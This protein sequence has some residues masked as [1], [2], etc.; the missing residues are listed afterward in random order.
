MKQKSIRRE[1]MRVLGA[2]LLGI[3]LMTLPLLAN[4]AKE[5][6]KEGLPAAVTTAAADKP[7]VTV[8]PESSVIESEMQD[9]RSLVEEQRAELEAQRMAL[10][11]AQLKMETLE[12]KMNV[13]P[14]EPA[15]TSAITST[16]ISS[17]SPASTAAAGT[18]SSAAAAMTP[19][20]KT[21]DVAP[22][23]LRIGS[24]Y[25]T[26][27]G[28]M[29]F[30]GVFRNHN[31]GG[32]IGSNFAGLPYEVTNTSGAINL[33]NH[34]TESRLNMQNSRLG[35]RIDAMVKGA[36]VIGY[37]ESDFLGNNPANVSVSSNS[38]TLRS[39]LYWVDVTKNKWEFLGGQTWSLI[40][41]GRSGISPLPGNLFF[42]QDI[43]VNYQAGL[44]WG[45]IPEFR[46][47][48]HPSS[49][50]AIAFALDNQEQ[51]VG[52]SAGGPKITLPTGGTVVNG[53]SGLLGSN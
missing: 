40:T 5:A 21:E 33:L 52:G 24:A 28:F 35:L 14:L 49:K 23:Q 46:F 4:N 42:S 26:P 38:N 9:L 47:V 19:Q 31:A 11:A 51:Y 17:A 39:R 7:K 2:V 43:D 30:T 50:A 12:K 20:Q 3:S 22:L 1:G 45:R 18:L 25:I 16:A 44:F 10:K 34:A 13:T 53:V 36:H 29:D 48:Y 41:P 15:S 6:G 8:K 27:V 37:M 32:G